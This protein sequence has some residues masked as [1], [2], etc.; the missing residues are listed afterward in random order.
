MGCLDPGEPLLPRHGA[1]R[2]KQALA[3]AGLPVTIRLSDLRHGAAV[4]L[5]AAG[6]HSEVAASRV[7]HTSTA[8][9]DDTYAHVQASVDAAAATAVGAVLDGA[10]TAG[11]ARRG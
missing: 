1:R 3:R 9:F 6:V 11:R 10:S 5:L 2:F 7:E 8:L 4:A